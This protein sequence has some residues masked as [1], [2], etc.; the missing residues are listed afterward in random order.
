[1]NKTAKFGKSVRQFL[2]NNY[3]SIDDYIH[4]CRNYCTITKESVIILL[5]G[6]LT[7]GFIT[8]HPSLVF[9][10]CYQM[11]VDLFDY[12]PELENQ[13]HFNSKGDLVHFVRTPEGVVDIVTYVNEDIQ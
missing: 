4:R 1:M 3:S 9:L 10:I 2:T 6:E 7:E 11:N 8:D 12:F 13:Q 5:N